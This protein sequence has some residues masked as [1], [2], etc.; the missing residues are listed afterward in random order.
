MKVS[1]FV[2]MSCALLVALCN[3]S[4]SP[5]FN[6]NVAI[7][8]GIISTFIFE[9]MLRFFSYQK[10]DKEAK[11]QNATLARNYVWLLLS[12]GYF[13]SKLFKEKIKDIKK[14]RDV[15]ADFIK[16]S[17]KSNLLSSSIVFLVI[18][19]L[20]LLQTKIDIHVYSIIYNFL[21][22]FVSFRVLSRSSEIIY[23]FVNDVFDDEKDA[24]TLLTKFDRI[25]LALNSYVEN[26]LNFASLYF[27]YSENK[28]SLSCLFDSIGRSTISNV[29]PAKDDFLLNIAIYGQVVTS[30]VLVVLSLAVY[31]SR[32][33]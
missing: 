12:P 30:L 5:V 3:N 25:K 29:S 15:K 22:G 28:S 7:I 6:I 9:F 32:K 16:S 23:A 24:T 20:D 31:V 18:T 1:L 4:L 33:R 21:I 17:N 26:I 19:V 27:L 11:G 2:T 13:F 8:I 14:S 10:L